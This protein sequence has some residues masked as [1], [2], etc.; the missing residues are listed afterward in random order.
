MM[1]LRT[2]VFSAATI[3][4]AAIAQA[5]SGTA[6][7]SAAVA[8]HTIKV[9]WPI[10]Q[11]AFY[12][13]ETTANMGDEI[14]FEMYPANHSVVRMDPSSPC[15]PYDYAGHPSNEFWW[16]GF[17]PTQDTKP[18]LPTYDI[19]VNT[20]DP[21]WFYCSA[22]GSCKTYSMVGVINVNNSDHNLTEV[23][24]AATKVNFSLSPGEKIPDESGNVPGS[25][26]SA[27]P[28][29]NNQ[30]NALSGGAI[31]GI[32]IGSIAAFS[33]VG[34]LF[35]LVGRKKKAQEVKE[36]N[37]RDAEIAAMAKHDQQPP[38]YSD[39]AIDPRYSMP[40]GSPP[41]HRD[42]FFGGKSSHQSMVA[43]HTGGSDGYEARNPHRLSELPSQNYDPVEIYTPGLPEQSM[44][45]PPIPNE[46]LPDQNGDDHERRR[47]TYH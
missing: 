16:S 18:P 41:P 43:E 27:A 30:S 47:D 22:P 3:F 4:S 13:E 25:S 19:K 32:V 44:G 21:I 42:T 24:A 46:P 20:A 45:F 10:G 31:A 2:T 5:A 8:T 29:S 9:G 38:V 23:K 36:K 37:E 28:S 26:P 14:V 12:P 1:L 35:F 40:P 11:H 15:V 33:L 39:P 34:I 7:S 17:F 6:T